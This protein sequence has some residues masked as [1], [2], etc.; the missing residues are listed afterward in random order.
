MAGHSKWSNIQHRKSRQ[1]E[2]RGKIWTRLIK[3]ITIASR[4]GGS[5]PNLNP[6]LRLAMDKAFYANMPKDNIIR[7]I[8]RGTKTSNTL[9][10]EE[11]RYEG[12]VI[13]GAAIIID[14]LTDNHIR[15]IAELRSIFSKFGGS[16]GTAGS[17]IFM[18]KEYGQLLYP[19]GTDEDMVMKIALEVGAEDII[20]SDKGVIQVL[21]SPDKFSAIR[22]NMEK[23][24]FKAET[25]ELIMKPITKIV[26]VGNDAIKIQKLL[27]IL[28]N[29]DDVQEVYSN[30]VIENNLK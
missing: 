4:I 23:L 27:D 1:D 11:V 25:A 29:L 5:E 9:R 16:I 22:F 8:Q 20:S 21:T 3:E 28:E 18:F 26:F 7:A 19:P 10:Y 30:I 14:C 24:G 15:T 17:V 12:Y 13:N 2:K 6:R